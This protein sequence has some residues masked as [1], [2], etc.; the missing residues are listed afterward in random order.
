M[1]CP[2]CDTPETRVVDS[3]PADGGRSVRRRRE[4]LECRHRFTT[5][6]RIEAAAVV[7]KRDG[8]LEPFDSGKVRRG[9]E[10]AL[11]DRRVR[12][13]EIDR[14]VRSVETWMAATS[15]EVSSIEIGR[16]VLEG[17]RDLDKAAYLRFASVHKE[18]EGA[19]DFEREMAAL[20]DGAD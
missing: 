8:T 15:G 18:F 2:F 20:E 19:D 3:R 13:S 11:A 5:Y 12:P 1:E 9:I 14:L 7:S 6:E 17:L 10:R 4:C 16:R